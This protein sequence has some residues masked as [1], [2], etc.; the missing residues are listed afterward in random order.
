MSEYECPSC[1]NMTVRTYY[2]RS[3]LREFP[4]LL[5]QVWCPVCRKYGGSTGPMPPGMTFDDPLREAAA[6]RWQ[7]EGTGRF[8][9]LDRFWD[10]GRL[11]QHPVITAGG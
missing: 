4:S 5:V 7:V 10:A 9:E 11:P 2:Q 1:H 8:D 3:D 6:G